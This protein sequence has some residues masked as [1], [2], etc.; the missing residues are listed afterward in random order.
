MRII[1]IILP[2][3]I[4]LFATFTAGADADLDKKTK[5]TLREKQTRTIVSNRTKLVKIYYTEMK[6]LTHTTRSKKNLK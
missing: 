3:P 2:I 1:A 6:N 4:F 5:I